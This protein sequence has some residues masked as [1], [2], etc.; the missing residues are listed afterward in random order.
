VSILTTKFIKER[1]AVARKIVEVLDEATRM[2]MTDFDKY[3]AILPKYTAIKPDQVGIVAKPYL[4]PWKELNDTDLKSYQAL[5]DVFQKEGVLKERIDVR[6]KILK[7][8][9]LK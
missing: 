7:P 2:A 9:D 8:A 6:E 3:R 1:P 4:R 5:V